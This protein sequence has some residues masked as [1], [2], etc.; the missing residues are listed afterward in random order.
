[1]KTTDPKK[2]TKSGSRSRS[3]SRRRWYSSHERES[4]PSFQRRMLWV[5]LSPKGK[6]TAPIF[7]Q[8]LPQK[9]HAWIWQVSGATVEFCKLPRTFNKWMGGRGSGEANLGW[10]QWTPFQE[11]HLHP[12]SSISI[13]TASTLHQVH[14]VHPAC[15]HPASILHPSCISIPYWRHIGGG[16]VPQK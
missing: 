13:H 5:K 6:K 7:W 4:I 12:T 2:E 16:K 10:K 3:R 9:S 11:L 8:V 15:I 1:M 14:V